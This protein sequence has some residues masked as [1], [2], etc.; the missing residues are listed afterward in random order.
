MCSGGG[1][2]HEHGA[3]SVLSTIFDGLCCRV[4]IQSFSRSVV[5]TGNLNGPPQL[6]GPYSDS[7]SKTNSKSP[8]RYTSVLFPTTPCLD[9]EK[10]SKVIYI[11]IVKHQIKKIQILIWSFEP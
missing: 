9:Q 1:Q 6:T 10:S 8:L 7:V 4:V 2:G 5:P 3:D 11:I